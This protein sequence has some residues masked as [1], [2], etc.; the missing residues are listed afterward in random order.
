MQIDT[1]LLRAGALGLEVGKHPCRGLGKTCRGV[2]GVG[3]TRQ[4]RL[5]RFITHLGIAYARLEVIKPTGFN[6]Q[7]TQQI[8]PDNTYASRPIKVTLLEFA[9]PVVAGSDINIDC[10]DSAQLG[11]GIHALQLGAVTALYGLEGRVSSLYIGQGELVGGTFQVATE[12]LDAVVALV[13]TRT[14][15]T[16]QAQVAI[17]NVKVFVEFGES[18]GIQLAVAHV[19]QAV[20]AILGGIERIGRGE[21]FLL[22]LVAALV[23]FHAA[24]DIQPRRDAPVER[25]GCLVALLV[26]DE[27]LALGLPIGVLH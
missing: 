18:L 14:Q 16:A 3:L 5:V 24:R 19:A 25:D 2:D 11:S 20:V 15:H 7:L 10:T 22:I 1:G 13:K 8:G 21:E 9:R 6:A 26:V 23:I 4:E 17:S 27:T 12:A